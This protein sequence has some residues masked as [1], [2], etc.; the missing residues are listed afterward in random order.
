MS[1]FFFIING[2]LWFKNKYTLKVFRQSFVNWWYMCWLGFGVYD[3]SGISTSYISVFYCLHK[4]NFLLAFWN[5]KHWD[6]KTTYYCMKKYFVI[7]VNKWE[8]K[9]FFFLSVWQLVFLNMLYQQILNTFF[10]N[11]LSNKFL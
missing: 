1:N 2:I 11:S 9:I 10:V 3:L 7:V 4:L 8:I 6:C 5:L